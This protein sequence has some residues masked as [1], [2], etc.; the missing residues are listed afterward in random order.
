MDEMGKID[1]V[2]QKINLDAATDVYISVVDDSPCCGTDIHLT[3]GATGLIADSYQQ[4]RENQLIFLRESK[5]QKDG[6]AENNPEQY[7]YFKMIWDVRNRHI[8]PN[9]PENY[10]FMLLPCCPHKV[11]AQGKKSW[12]WYDG[13]PLLSVLP[14]PVADPQRPCGGKCDTCLGACAGH[15][16]L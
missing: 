3:K 6:L 9:M 5:K 14:L 4:R 7:N 10:V 16:L 15:Y 2:K 13:G 8:V 11:C 1:K 12:C